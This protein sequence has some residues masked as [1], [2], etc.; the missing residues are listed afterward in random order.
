M[1]T[2][3][4]IILLCIQ[5]KDSCLPPPSKN[6]AAFYCHRHQMHLSINVAHRLTAMAV[7]A[8]SIQGSQHL[9]KSLQESGKMI[10]L[11]WYN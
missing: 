9:L 4:T 6:W 2:K 5:K 3:Y 11:Q 1:K 8:D 10:Q 7:L